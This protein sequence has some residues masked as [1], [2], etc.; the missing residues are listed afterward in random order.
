MLAGFGPRY[1]KNRKHIE[2]LFGHEQVLL[3]FHMFE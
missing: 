1:T 3:F 2:C